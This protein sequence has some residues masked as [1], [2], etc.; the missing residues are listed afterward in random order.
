[1]NQNHLSKTNIETNNPSNITLTDSAALKISELILEEGNGNPVNLRVFIKGGG[2]SGF[3]YHFIFDEKINEKDVLI[4]KIVKNKNKSKST[5]K[6]KEENNNDCEEEG[7]NGDGDGSIE[8]T[9]LIDP[10]SLQYLIGAEI[11]YKSDITG[12]QFIIR[13][14]LAKTTCGC[15]S[16]FSA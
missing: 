16:S 8:V 15:G 14:P 9:V 5:N 11:D 6:E 1:M 12:E 10:L 2:C 7:G 3:E 4:K 13:N